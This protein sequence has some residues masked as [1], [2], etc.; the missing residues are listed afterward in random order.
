MVPLSASKTKRLLY[1]VEPLKVDMVDTEEDDYSELYKRA[2]GQA[3]Q[4]MSAYQA[5]F[6]SLTGDDKAR[7]NENNDHDA[8][9][10]MAGEMDS[11]NSSQENN[12]SNN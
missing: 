11:V 1:K 4:G 2:Q 10:K 3:S 6:M 9:K 12:L 5:F 8:F 7:L